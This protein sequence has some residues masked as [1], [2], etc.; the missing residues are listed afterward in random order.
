MFTTTA[1]ANLTPDTLP[2]Q[3]HFV[4]SATLALVCGVNLTP[5]VCVAC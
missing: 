1:D 3:L 5:A 4:F 2:N